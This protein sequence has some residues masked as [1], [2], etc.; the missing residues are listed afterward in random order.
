MKLIKETA[1]GLSLAAGVC[2]WPQGFVVGRRGLS[3]AACA[4]VL[5][6]G[7]PAAFADGIYIT[8]WV[9]GPS[10]GEITSIPI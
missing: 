5:L 8:G 4:F 6:T 7:V 10:A 2:R 9:T 1:G 3:L